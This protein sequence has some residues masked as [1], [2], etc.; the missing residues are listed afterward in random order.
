MPQYTRV[1]V[2]FLLAAALLGACS[3][4]GPDDQR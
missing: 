4:Q 1:Y 3:A 2:V